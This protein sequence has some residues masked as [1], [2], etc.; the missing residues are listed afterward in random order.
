MPLPLS[1]R[2]ILAGLAASLATGAAG[3]VRAADLLP[4]HITPET[5]SAVKKGL[6]YLA[7]CGIDRSRLAF[8]GQGLRDAA[9]RGRA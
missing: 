4:K 2:R 9:Q 1:R 8:R 3:V 5:V 7:A 6:D